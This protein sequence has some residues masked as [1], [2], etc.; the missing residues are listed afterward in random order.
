MAKSGF[1]YKRRE[2]TVEDIRRKASE[3]SRDYD[4]LFK[5]DVKLFKPGEGENIIRILPATWGFQ[6]WTD[7]DL[8]K[9][10]EADIKRLEEEEEKYGNGWDFP[11]FVHY[12]VGPDNASY[13]CRE[14]MLG[15]RCPICEAKAKTRDAD[16]ADALAPTK[17]GLTWI[18]DR[19]AEKEGPQL[20]SMPFQKIRNEVYARSV[21]KK[22]GTPIIIDGRPPDY[23]GYDVTFNRAGKDDRTNY[24]AVEVDRE[25]TYIHED[26]KTQDRWLAYIM[27]HPLQEI[28]NFY[29]EEHIE[30][31]LFGRV[32]AR[33]SS[34][35]EEED[36]AAAPTGR[37]DRGSSRRPPGRGGSAEAT[38]RD[39]ID[40]EEGEAEAA[41]ERE[42]TRR[43]RHRAPETGVA[44]R[45]GRP[46]PEE[47][48]VD[49]DP[50]EPDAEEEGEAAPARGRR[51]A[52]T[53]SR[54]VGRR[55]TPP[56]E[57]EEEGEEDASPSEQAR[58]RL[59]SLRD[60]RR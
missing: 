44:A 46:A 11:I 6:P 53:I 42:T 22:H 56:A 48:P 28:L 13:L 45:R 19:N 60:R 59:R 52:G 10:S 32:S 12:G 29:D 16:E 50:E 14:K 49:P 31:V 4:N 58:G 33:R 39:Y 18:I 27:E 15:E 35:E 21:D 2:R 1:K 34:S 23:E 47:D 57:E 51:P 38:E 25:P 41:P 9:M 8:E 3:G 55:G 43:P 24:T 36:G 20:W 54:A 7:E 5:G 30:K 37:R 26:Q 40:E 17:R